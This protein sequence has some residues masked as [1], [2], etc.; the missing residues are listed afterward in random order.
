MTK[1]LRSGN[2]GQRNKRMSPHSH[3]SN[4]HWRIPRQKVKIN[5]FLFYPVL[6]GV[7]SSYV[8]PCGT[9]RKEHPRKGQNISHTHTR[10]FILVVTR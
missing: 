2:F 3:S 10:L 7:M 9:I 8:L 5:I 6:L 1:M 4:G